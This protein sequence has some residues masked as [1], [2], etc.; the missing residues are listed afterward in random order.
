MSLTDIFAKYG[1][2]K[3]YYHDYGPTYERYIKPQAIRLVLE[4]GVA[5]GG[6]CMSWH[7]WMPKA[8]IWGVDIVPVVPELIQ[9]Q[10]RVH[11]VAGDI[12]DQ[13]TIDQLPPQFDFVCDDGS[14]KA[15]DIHKAMGYLWPRLMKGG[16]Y[17]VED[18]DY[19]G[20]GIIGHLID[21]YRPK[22]AHNHGE[23]LL[24]RK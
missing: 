21:T 24:M 11:F 17:C 15:E 16:W 10:P 19:T 6:G 12:N 3:G 20:R 18:L 13:T 5:C 4:I 22:E 1:T 9:L 8:E 2:D 7:D 23:L 14:H